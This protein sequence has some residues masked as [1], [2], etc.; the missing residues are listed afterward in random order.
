MT[1]R[2]RWK[3]KQKQ[4]SKLFLTEQCWSPRHKLSVLSTSGACHPE[5]FILASYYN[6]TYI[7]NNHDINNN[8]NDENN[9]K[10]S[11]IPNIKNK[12][13][14]CIFSKIKNMQPQKPNS[15]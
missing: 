3:K 6:L 7:A 11:K 9:N 8:N 14:I 15:P 4:K 2:H 13:A 10:L 1:D 5:G 12:N